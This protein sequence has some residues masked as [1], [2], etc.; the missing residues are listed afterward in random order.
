MDEANSVAQL[1]KLANA[2]PKNAAAWHRLGNALLDEGKL[3]RGISAFRRALRIDDALAEVH[4][5]LGSAYFDKQWHAE[6][7]ACFRKAIAFRPE[8]GIAHANL[9]AALRAQGKL[10]DSRRAFQRALLLKLRAM[11]PAWLRW[12]VGAGAA[13][14]GAEAPAALAGELKAIAETINAGRTQQGLELAQKLRE[15]YP[16]EPDVL[17]ILG[18]AFEHTRD[19]QAAIDSVRAALERKPERTEYHVVHARILSRVGRYGEAH[20]AAAK[21]L[22]LEPG[23]ATTFAAVAGIYS[24]WRDDLALEAAQHAVALDA[25]CD[26]AH[27][28]VATALW[29][30]GRVEEAEAPAREAVRLNPKQLG[31]RANLALILKDLGRIDESRALYHRMIDEAPDYPKMCMDMGTLATE[32]EG[33]MESARRWYRKA[34]AVAGDPRAFLSE[35]IADLM[36]GRFETGWDLYER[37]KETREQIPQQAPFAA[38]PAWQGERLESGRLLLYAEQGL[39]DEIMF[40]SMFADLAQRAPDT[41][42]LCDNRLDRLFSR[43]FPTFTVLGERRDNFEAQVAKLEGVVCA[44][45]AGSL[46]RHFRRRAADFPRHRGYL[47]ADPANVAGWRER[48]AGLGA[49]LKVGVSWIGGFQRTGRSR[50]SLSLEQLRPLLCMP[51]VEWISLQYTPAGEEIAAFREATGRTLH[52][53]AGVTQDIDQL[54]SLIG[55]LD[56]VISVCNTT[57][58]VAGATGKEVLVMAP[59]VPE[60]RYGLA[61]ERMIWYP[62]ARVFRQAAYGNWDG[63]IARVGEELERRLAAGAAHVVDQ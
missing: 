63:V 32:C 47:A 59:F 20:E 36:E 55:A 58:H 48:L 21:A 34:Q 60:W 10:T 62:S 43:S 29:A 41:V 16:E 45:S 56:L 54:A 1:H 25:A 9:G 13:R 22:R 19:Y 37:R 2:E 39:G 17:N 15:R 61:S 23:S 40:A 4:N 3:D 33:D 50:R 28:N 30:L 35:G 53:F 18:V 14:A 7:E 49:G 42:L 51:G 44:V 12:K 31:F 5:D 57:V 46:G 38:F 11:L 8:H 26:I 6:A 24:H 52:E 27:G